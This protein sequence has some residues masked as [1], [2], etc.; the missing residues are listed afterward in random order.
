[1]PNITFPRLEEVIKRMQTDVQKELPNSNPY[2]PNS[3]LKAI[4]TGLAGRNF[5]NFNELQSLLNNLFL[6]TSIGFFISEWGSIYGL[7]QI[8]ATRASGNITVTGDV[9]T[10]IDSG[11]VLTSTTSKEYTT[12]ED[13]LISAVNENVTLTFTGKT[14]TATT[15]DG[16]DFA[17]GIDVTIS[18]ATGINGVIY[19]GTFEITVLDAVTFIYSVLITPTSDDSG[20][21]S[22]DI[23]SIN[24]ESTDFGSDQN[25]S[26]GDTLT[27]QS[28]I[29]G[30]DNNDGI[31]GADGIIGGKDAET[32][33]AFR[34]RILNRI[35]NPVAQFSESAI[36]QQALLVPGVTRV[37]VQPITPAPGQVTVYFVRDNDADI[38]PDS[39]EVADVRQSIL[40]IY[41][42]SND[43]VDLF[44]KA[45][46]PVPVDFTFDELEPDTSTMQEAIQQNLQQF[47]DDNA[48]VGDD[49][50]QL[51]YNSAI[52]S[53][54]D[55]QTGNQVTDF[56][57]TTPLGDVTIQSNEIGQLR[58]VTFT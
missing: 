6:T 7:T 40:V 4:I 53:T 26:S 35:R 20:I 57:L 10:V 33:E 41:P 19:N 14:I 2:L 11:E 22:A 9:G 15:Q 18:G 39:G 32:D 34:D 1:M 55:P 47:F 56:L 45:P 17:T 25:L 50:L 29:A 49:I 12:S 58:N 16:H 28:I 30:V 27:F 5:E 36:T 44:V 31:V 37:F 23:A 38:I 43:P 13:A 8:N 21:A 51:G 54:I 3:Y 24:V 52:F 42:A 46:T 48:G